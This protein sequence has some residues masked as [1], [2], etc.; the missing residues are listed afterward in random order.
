MDGCIQIDYVV[1]RIYFIQHFCSG[2][3]VI[4]PESIDVQ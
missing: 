1:Q 3:D 4:L 2:L